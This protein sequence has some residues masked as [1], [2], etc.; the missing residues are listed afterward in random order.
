[1]KIVLILLDGLGDRSYRRFGDKTPLQAAVTPHLDRLAAVGSN[2]L[3]HAG[4]PGQCLPS[5]TAHYLLFGYPLETFPGRGLLEAVGEGISFQDGDVAALAHLSHVRWEAHG[6]VLVDK[7]PTMPDEDLARLFDAIRAGRYGGCDFRLHPTGGHDALLTVHGE[8]S[9]HVSDSDPM[10]PGWP[11]AQICPLEMN[12]EPRRA[13]RTAKALNAYLTDC[14]TTLEDHAVNR[15]RHAEGL[16]VANFLATQRCGRR[17]ALPPFEDKWGMNGRLIASGAVY[18]GLAHE[19]GL[20]FTQVEDSAAPGKDLAQRIDLAL[21]DVTHGFIHVHTKVPDEAAHTGDPDR[22]RRA[23]GILDT[24]LEGLVDA[25]ESRREDLLV[26]VTADH[27]TPSRS[28][29]IHSGE[30]V[31]VMLTG[32]NVRRDAVSSYDEISAAGGSLGFLRG[33]ELMLMLLNYSDRAALLGHRLDGRIRPY[34]S[35]RYV[36]F[37]RRDK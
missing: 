16:A 25:V 31:P 17:V 34:V 32:G 20:T 30:P 19:L 5:E 37:E 3:F 1:M 7:R 11:M 23:I 13:E 18:K 28:T 10:A 15:A 35:R 4:R 29:L 6:P 2:G 33:D 22:K 14:Y 21:E 26:A 12:P 36:A 8:V 27:S 9:P 24:G